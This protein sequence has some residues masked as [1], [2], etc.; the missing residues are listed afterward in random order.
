MIDA[1]TL[2]QYR[3]LRAEGMRAAH[4]LAYART[5]TSPDD[6]GLTWDTDNYP[7]SATGTLDGFT[8]TATCVTDEDYQSPGTFEDGRTDDYG[9]AITPSPDAVDARGVHFWVQGQA[10]WFTPEITEREH[11]DGLRSMGYGKVQARDL[12][13]SYVQ[14]DMRMAARPEAYGLVVKVSKRGIPLGEAAIWGYSVD[15]DE[16]NAR[17]EAMLVNGFAEYGLVEQAIE[18]AQEALAGLVGAE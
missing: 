1:D 8:V 13:R 6:S 17:N 16:S 12:A 10:R 5:I 9:R 2:R 11:F 3:A 18:E 15:S 7:P 4:A 14:S